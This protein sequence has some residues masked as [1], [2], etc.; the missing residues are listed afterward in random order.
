[1]SFSLQ[2]QTQKEIRTDKE[3]KTFSKD[4]WKGLEGGK[5]E[6]R[7]RSTSSALRKHLVQITNFLLNYTHTTL[8]FKHNT[9]NSST[10]HG[11]SPG[12]CDYVMP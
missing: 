5:Q 11:N 2:T 10:T 3:A 4:P 9:H 12:V 6:A 1:V 7:P 8:E